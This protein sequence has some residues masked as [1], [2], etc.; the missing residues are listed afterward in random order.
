M[1]S[2]RQLVLTHTYAGVNALRR[3]MREF[4]VPDGAW[5]DAQTAGVTQVRVGAEVSRPVRLDNGEMH[6]R[7]DGGAGQT[8][9][10]TA[11]RPAPEAARQG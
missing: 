9:T 8:C 10:Q 5:S 4:R 2:D 1:A 6:V 11:C 7:R 3:K